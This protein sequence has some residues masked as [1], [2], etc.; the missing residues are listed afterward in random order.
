MATY[1][2]THHN[3]TSL[4]STPLMVNSLCVNWKGW[5]NKI[6]KETSL[7]CIP[8][9]YPPSFL[10]R[11]NRFPSLAHPRTMVLK[12]W[13]WGAVSISLRNWL[14]LQI[15]KLHPKPTKSETLVG[16]WGCTSNTFCNNSPWVILMF[17]TKV[18]ELLPQGKEY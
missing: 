18:W 9:L 8:S 16:E 4:G 12:V 3:L 7:S 14:E 5:I 13:P 6:S 11:I 10:G 15:L 1:W 2:G 17:I